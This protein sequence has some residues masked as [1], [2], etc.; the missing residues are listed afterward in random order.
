MRVLAPGPAAHPLSDILYRLALRPRKCVCAWSPISRS[1]SRGDLVIPSAC[2]A[3]RQERAFLIVGPSVW[4]GLPSDPCSLPHGTCLFLFKNFL[5]LSLLTEA[6]W[7][8]LR[9]DIWKGTI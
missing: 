6:G 5:R 2:T 7:E 9:I 4:N 1:A 8:C 3:T